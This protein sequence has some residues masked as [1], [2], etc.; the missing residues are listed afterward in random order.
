MLTVKSKLLVQM[1][2]LHCLTQ[3]LLTLEEPDGVVS[4]I[5]I[6]LFLAPFASYCETEKRC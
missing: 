1:I 5:L 6:Q 2:V 4:D 3:E